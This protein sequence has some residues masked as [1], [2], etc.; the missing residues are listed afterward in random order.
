[1]LSI[2][3]PVYNEVESLAPLLAEI[4]QV[5]RSNQYEL[6]L[7]LVD[8]G[9]RDGSWET[10]RRL[11]AADPRVRGIRFRRNFGKSAA[12]SAGF[13]AARGETVMTLDADLQDDPREIPRFVELL[14][15]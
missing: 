14:E 11:A 3:I 12:L 5:A 4:D 8:D 10:I 2:V 1:M 6:D 9:S 7:I 15:Q 13:R